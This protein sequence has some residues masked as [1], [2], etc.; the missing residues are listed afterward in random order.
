MTR[1]V[2][3]LRAGPGVTV[4]DLGRPGYLA[5]GLSCGGAA[6]PVA[7]A[8]GAALLEQAVSCAAIEVAGAVLEVEATAPVRFALTGA[9]M[10][11]QIGSDG[12]SLAWNASH[13]LDAGETL[14]LAPGGTGSYGYLHLGGGI[15]TPERVGGRGAHLAAGLG[16]PL[17]RGDRL[18]LAADPQPDAS[19][20]RLPPDD[21]F[22]GGT[23]RMIPGPQTGLF[24]Q[25][26]LTRFLSTP[27]ERTA[28]GNRQGV[29][30]GFSGE[31]FRPEG[32]LHLLSEVIVP[33]DIQ[34]TGDGTP[35]V[36]GPECQ[37]IGGY[38]RIGTVL[39]QD[40]PKVLQAAPGAAL[41]FRMVPLESAAADYLSPEAQTRALSRRVEPLVRDP[42]HVPNL[43]SYEFISGVTAGRELSGPDGDDAGGD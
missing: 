13:R 33:G 41:R 4:Q 18:T 14:R 17:D 23:I 22:S 19:P 16:A 36:L 25:A 38:P 35:Y 43:L 8:E 21:R 26:L 40:L 20:R 24:P 15:D 27:F 31:G 39:P 11:A 34:I 30:L 10:R 9:P 6:D 3:I 7:L 2:H 29:K 5:Q 28:W 37:T 1:E 32:G 12:R 42:R